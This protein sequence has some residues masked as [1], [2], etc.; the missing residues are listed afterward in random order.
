LPSG[1]LLATAVDIVGSSAIEQGVNCIINK[2]S[3]SWNTFAEN[4]ADGAISAV[5]SQLVSHFTPRWMASEEIPRYIR[6]IKPEA[7]ANGIKGT[8]QLMNYL[9]QKQV[10]VV[11]KNA[12]VNVTSGNVTEW[13]NNSTQTHNLVTPY[14]HK[15]VVQ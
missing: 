8:R 7:S 13:L 3:W 12:F 4:V 15:C 9:D 11:T 14:R 10:A 1:G 6:D 5:S 2:S